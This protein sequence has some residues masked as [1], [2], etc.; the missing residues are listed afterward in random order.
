[1]ELRNKVALITGGSSGIGLALARRLRR[2][3]VKVALVARTQRTLDAAVAELG[4]DGAVAF[5]LDVADRAAIDRLPAAVL[6]RLGRLD[7]LVNNAGLNHRG[8]A[9]GRTAEQLAEV[10]QVNLTAPVYLT[11]RVL[12]VLPRG[13]AILNIASLAGKVPFAEQ[14]AYCASKAGLRAFSMALR[15]ELGARDIQVSCIN[16]GPVDTEFFG[17]L[18]QASNLTFSQ[19][20]SS[21]EAVAECIFDCLQQNRAEVDIPMMS[22]KLST[23]GYLFPGFKRALRPLLEKRGAK[24]REAYLAKKGIPKS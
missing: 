21:P 9:M 17:D 4:A 3:G 1:M 15:E 14:A 22:G 23:V 2:E 11:R 19:P 10:I 8:P 18:R 13:G 12:D 16:P 20:M 24:N 6:D 7:I 5:A